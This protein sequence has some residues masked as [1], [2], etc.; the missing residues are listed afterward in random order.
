MT[1]DTK[2]EG[3]KLEPMP[4]ALLAEI[5]SGGVVVLPHEFAKTP[6][7]EKAEAATV[8][9]P[10]EETS[11]AGNLTAAPPAHIKPK[12]GEI[13]WLGNFGKSVLV[14]VKDPT[15]L[16]INDKDYEL[17]TKI[18]GSVGLS[19]ADIALVNA[20]THSLQYNALQ[21]KLPAAVGLYFGIEPV[22]IGAPI[23]FPHFQVQ[24][25]NNTKFLYA[26]S[27]SELN[28]TDPQA[29]SLKKELW[30]ALKKIFN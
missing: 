9:L 8:I 10:K 13:S 6:L 1:K 18:L 16:H 3:T 21:E 22:T 28:G 24:P 27:I 29:I 30:T 2:Q 20:A 15:A 4:G 23:K 19:T 12:S 17:L 7:A 11:I 25:W 26:P 14:V 5:F